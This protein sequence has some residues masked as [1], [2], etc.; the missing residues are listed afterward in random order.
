MTHLVRTTI[1]RELRITDEMVEAARQQEQSAR[2]ALKDTCPNF[3]WAD[4]HS[5]IRQSEV[6]VFLVAKS[7]HARLRREQERQQRDIADG[8]LTPE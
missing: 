1:T 4:D 3:C 5:S 7:H 8:T 2:A 6:G